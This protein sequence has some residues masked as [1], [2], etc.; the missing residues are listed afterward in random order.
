MPLEKYA[1]AQYATM[2]AWGYSHWID[3]RSIAPILCEE[4]GLEVVLE[5]ECHASLWIERA[6]RLV[7]LFAKRA[8]GALE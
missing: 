7:E 2:I 8:M 6:S 4:S 1:S 3:I 5:K